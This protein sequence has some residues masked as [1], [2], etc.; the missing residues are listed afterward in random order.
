MNAISSVKNVR[1]IPDYFLR[2]V[3]TTSVKDKMFINF[4]VFMY[5]Y[6]RVDKTRVAS[7]KI[8]PSKIGCC[9]YKASSFKYTSST[10]YKYHLCILSYSWLRP[11]GGV[12]TLPQF[13]EN[14]K[15]T[16]AGR[17]FAYL[18]THLFRNFCESFIP[19]S[20]K[21]RSPRQVEWS[22]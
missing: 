20:C 8:G 3:C 5:V 6:M 13:F 21:V 2:H 15:K 17:V 7:R 16:A 11:A 22:Q 10:K 12:W 14:V 1:I 19:R 18:I 4:K 9:W